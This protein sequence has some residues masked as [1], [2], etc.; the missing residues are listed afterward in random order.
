MVS[1]FGE[2]G[3]N[4]DSQADAAELEN[5][6]GIAKHL[7]SIDIAHSKSPTGVGDFHALARAGTSNFV[8][9]DRMTMRS[10]EGDEQIVSI[11]CGKT[12]QRCWSEI[13]RLRPN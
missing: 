5:S 10:R 13:L 9:D 1:C 2:S 3:A 6:S 7:E 8:C 4:I 11:V 12:T